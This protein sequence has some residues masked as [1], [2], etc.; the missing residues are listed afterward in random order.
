L[1]R[2]R[3]K[4]VRSLFPGAF[5]SAVLKLE[6]W[7]QA[8]PASEHERQFT[9]LDEELINV[10]NLEAQQGESRLGTCPLPSPIVSNGK[11]IDKL[12]EKA[13]LELWKFVGI[14][15]NGLKDFLSLGRMSV[16]LNPANSD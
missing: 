3:V 4:R 5:F 6:A 7:S 12:T 15:V 16:G 11:L 2:K 14:I 13:R 10:R 9:S 8:R 1:Y